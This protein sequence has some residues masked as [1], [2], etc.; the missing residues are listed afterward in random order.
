MHEVDAMLLSSLAQV[1]SVA[2]MLAIPRPRK[3]HA[4]PQNGQSKETSRGRELEPYLAGDVS[5]AHKSASGDCAYRETAFVSARTM[6]NRCNTAERTRRHAGRKTVS[7][8]ESVG[9]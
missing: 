7:Q 4:Y 5:Q 9:E 8:P 2:L 1:K 3:S 6:S